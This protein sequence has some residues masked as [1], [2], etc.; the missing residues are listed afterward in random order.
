[1]PRFLYFAKD[2][3]GNPVKGVVEAKD[4]NIALDILHRRGLAILSLKQD[5]VRTGSKFNQIFNKVSL[6][7]LVLFTRQLATM[8][9]SGI[10]L[11]QAFEILYE[12]T[13]K[14]YFKKVIYAIK[15]D[16]ESGESLSN[17][18]SKFP[19]VFSPLYIYM[20][21]AGEASG[22]LSEI[23]NRLAAYLEDANKLISKVKGAMI[24]PVT[25]LTIAILITIGLLVFVVPRFKEMF[26]SLGGTLPLPT[27]ILIAISEGLKQYIVFVFIV[28]VILILAFLRLI[29]TEKGK[30]AFDAFMLRTPV[31]GDL[32]KKV[33]IA[34]F[35]KTLATLLRSGVPILDGLEIVA[36]VSGN[37]VVE[38]R[39]LAT[40]D[41]IKG[42][43]NISTPLEKAKIFPPMVYRMVAV[44]EQTGELEK[45]LNKIAEFYE[46]QVNSAVEALTSLMEPMIMVVLG[47][48]I[49]S[50]VMSLFL[51]IFNI[52]KLFR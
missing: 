5:T 27:R 15:E 38:Q 21:K 51:P 29:S 44:G 39:L 17:A 18:M 24:Y 30:Y 16:I 50:I 33:S 43:E 31:F 14:V 8:I 32:L 46:D 28:V 12:Q 49:G 36:K 13:T 42:G 20:V 35:A 9:E 7:D 11:P 25:V 45:M 40:K 3:S 23:L 1:M 34:K 47:T 2:A 10:P 4:R 26:E 37:K 6:M 48:L 41:N 22:A 52:S 19:D